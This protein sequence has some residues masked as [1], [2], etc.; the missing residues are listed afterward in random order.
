MSSF[1]SPLFR[2]EADAKKE[3][4]SV[5]YRFLVNWNRTHT[6]H[7]V[8]ANYDAIL[9]SEEAERREL[10]KFK[11]ENPEAVFVDFVQTQAFPQLSPPVPGL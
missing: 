7:S 1:P 9:F 11:Q 10:E 6:Q 4:R 8:L 2:Q 3:Q 5:S